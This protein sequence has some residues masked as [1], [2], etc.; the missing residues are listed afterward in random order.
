MNLSDLPVM[1]PVKKLA[2]VFGVSRPTLY[3]WAKDGKI[4]GKKIGKS[5]LFYTASV[6]QAINDLPDYQSMA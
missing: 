5:T 2:H 3:R 4:K 1:M 6:W